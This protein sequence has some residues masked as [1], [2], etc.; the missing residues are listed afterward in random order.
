MIIQKSKRDIFVS[1]FFWLTLFL[2]PVLPQYIYV[3]GGINVVNFL[4]VVF[5]VAYL[6]IGGKLKIVHMPKMTYLFWL[7]LIYSVVLYLLDADILKAGTY[8]LL[9]LI[10]PYIIIATVDTKNRFFKAVDILILGGVILGFIGLMETVV[11]LN[12]IQLLAPESMEFF[13]DVR[14]GLLRI[15]TTFGQPIG[16]GLYQVFIASLIYYRLNTEITAKKRNRLIIAYVISVL[17][18]FLTVSR[19]PFLAFIITQILFVY[20]KSK[21]KFLNYF[22]IAIAIAIPTIILCS[23][24]GINIPFIDD[25]V[26]AIA[27]IFWEDVNTD[28]AVGV[29]N[30]LEL[31][32]WVFESMNGSWIFGSG[33]SSVF[34]YEVYE[35]HT[36]TSIENQYL[37][38][39]FHT[40]IVGVIALIF[41]YVSVLVYARKEN[42]KH[43]KAFGEKSISFN[44]I[45]S[46]LF[47][48]YYLAGMGVQETDMTRTYVIFIALLIAYNRIGKMRY[49][50]AEER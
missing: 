38:T 41:S 14:Y 16:Y 34:E 43:G 15:M 9:F 39:F 47:T 25:L 36:K 48:V 10:F 7:Y 26:K 2:I 22:F 46:I 12:F 42:K 29:G 5:F 50:Q 31:W 21:R 23:L 37:N 24:I 27:S 49:L 19:I 6:L 32:H 18:I 28:N 35:W 1:L 11:S 13:H 8:A 33:I 17:N 4:M 40:G 45:I 44:S 30:R 20:S 3:V